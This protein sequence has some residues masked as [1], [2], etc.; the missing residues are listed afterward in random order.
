MPSPF[1]E[2]EESFC[3]P[4]PSGG[5]CRDRNCARIETEAPLSEAPVLFLHGHSL[6]RDDVLLK[7]PECRLRMYLRMCFVV[8]RARTSR[9]RPLACD[10]PRLSIEISGILKRRTTVPGLSLRRSSGD[11]SLGEKT[12]SLTRQRQFAPNLSNRLFPAKNM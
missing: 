7:I 11:P 6:I 5:S 3:T 10:S 9:G 2:W 1:E 4:P 12:P 8:A